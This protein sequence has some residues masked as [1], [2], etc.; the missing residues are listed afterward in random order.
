M[1]N[2]KDIFT[3]NIGQNVDMV[4]VRIP[5]GKFI[6]G[7]TGTGNTAWEAFGDEVEMPQH[8]LYLEEFWMGKY[9]ITNR[10]F[11]EFVNQEKYQFAK[12]NQNNAPYWL[13]GE[14]EKPNH[15]VT[16]VTW[17]DAQAFCK[18]VAKKSN[19]LTRLPTEAEWEK[20]ARGTD[21]RIFPWGNKL[22]PGEKKANGGTW[23][24]DDTTPVGEFSPQG[25]SPFGCVDMSGNVD[26]WVNSLFAQYPYQPQDGRESSVSPEE[27]SIWDNNP[28][29]DNWSEYRAHRHQRVY[30]GGCFDSQGFSHL[31]CAH[32]SYE[33]AEYRGSYNGFRVCFSAK[34]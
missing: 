18:W 30:R 1:P 25:D 15:P 23:Q 10:Q 26:E 7:S 32:R 34:A 5:A 8:T 17:Y 12:S 9:P 14:L 2:N 21:G 22:D 16:E 24:S 27:V 3:I 13:K 19:F 28:T 29:S 6:M 20:A 4:F 31:R 33:K 11:T